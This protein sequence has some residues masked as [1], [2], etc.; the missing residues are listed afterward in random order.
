MGGIFMEK[1][2]FTAEEK[3]GMVE[4]HLREGKGNQWI[5]ERYGVSPKTLCDWIEKYKVFGAEGLMERKRNHSYTTE[6]K[7]CAVEEYQAGKG[8]LRDICARYKIHSKKPPPFLTCE[9]SFGCEI[10]TCGQCEK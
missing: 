9:I 5:S 4:Q 2:R 1:N 8:S 3:I 7:R 10:L 6:L